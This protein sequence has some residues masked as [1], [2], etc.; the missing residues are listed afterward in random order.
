[1]SN[2]QTNSGGVATQVGIN[3][4][5]RVAAWMCV[6]ILAE[7][8]ASPLWGLSPD[9][10]FEFIRCE[11]EQPVD[12]LLIGTSKG[13]HAFIQVKHRILSVNKNEK[14]AVGS[15]LY[16]FVR[17][18]ICYRNKPNG[19]RSW[20]RSLNPVLDRL[21]LVTN[22]ESSST[23]KFH[24][25]KILNRLQEGLLL[26]ID[27]AAQNNDEKQAL[28][29][30]KYLLNSAWEK[31]TGVHITEDDMLQVLMLMRI[32]VLDVDTGGDDELGAKDRLRSSV[33]DE[34]SQADSVWEHLF[35]ACAM[36]AERSSGADRKILQNYLIN[37]QV[38]LKA[39]RSYQQDIQRLRQYSNSTLKLLK[40]LSIITMGK[41]KAI[42]IDRPSSK[43]LRD[44]SEKNSIVVVGEPGSGKSGALYDLAT[45]LISESRDV[46]FFAVDKIESRSIGSLRQEL[47][48]E[49]QLVDILQNWFGDKPGFLIIDAFDAAR[50]DALGQTLLDVIIA[51]KELQRWNIIVSIRNFDLQHNTRLH[52][53][54]AGSPIDDSFK[55]SLFSNLS[56]IFIPKL[57]INEWK[58]ITKQCPELG[59]LFINTNSKLQE[60][61]LIPFNVKLAAELLSIGVEEK[62]LTPIKTQIGLLDRYWGE[63]VIR[64]DSK[65][66]D[67]EILLRQAVKIMCETRSLVVS[68]ESIATGGGTLNE[69]LS[70]NILGQWQPSLAEAPDRYLLTFAHHI[71]FDYAVARLLLRGTKQNFISRLEEDVDLVIA[72][73]PSVV[74]HFQDKL[75]T[76]N[77]SFWDLTF[78]VIRSAKIPEIGKLI[79]PSTAVEFIEGID[80]FVPLIEA[81]LSES[82]LDTDIPTTAE[83]TLWHL[84]NAIFVEDAIKSNDQRNRLL[85]KP[86]N[87]LI[88][89][90]T[91]TP[92]VNSKIIFC[93]SPVLVML[94]KYKEH[95]SQDNQN[96]LGRAARRLL[97]FALKQKESNLS[98]VA[99]GI[100]AVCR[101][102]DTDST[103]S[104]SVLKQLLE[105]ERVSKYG[106]KELYRLAIEIEGLMLVD[107][108]LVEQVYLRAFTFFDYSEEKTPMGGS[109]IF[110]FTSTRTQDYDSIRYVLV[111]KYNFF[112]KKNPLNATR[113]LI[114][115]IE[116]EFF[117]QNKEEPDVQEKKSFDFSGKI[118]FVESDGSEIKD[119]GISSQYNKVFQILG[120]FEKHIKEI[121]NQEEKSEEL[122]QILDLIVEKNKAAIIWRRLLFLG[123]K[124]PVT[125]GKYLRS[126]AW[127]EPILFGMDTIHPVGEYLKAI[128]SYLTD[129]ERERVE[130]VILSPSIEVEEHSLQR[131]KNRLLGC[132]NSEFLVTDQAKRMVAEQ[133][134]LNAIPPNKPL[135][136]IGK[137]ESRVYTEEDYLLDNDV[138]LDKEPDATIQRLMKPARGF[139]AN[140]PNRDSS[141]TYLNETL[142]KLRILY[143][144]LLKEG[145]RIHSKLRDVAWCH[146]TEACQAVVSHN[147]LECSEEDVLFI[148]NVLLE[149]TS[150]EDPPYDLI[151]HT[152]FDKTP[153]WSPTTRI[154]A[155]S[156][157]VRFIYHNTLIDQPVIEAIKRLAFDPVPAVRFQI[158]SN[159]TLL[160]YSSPQL[161]WE[162]IERI[163]YEEKSMG[164]LQGFLNGTID[165]IARYHGDKTANYINIIFG[166]VSGRNDA[167]EAQKSY[168]GIAVG[169]YLWQKQA[170]CGDIVNKIVE[171]PGKFV[172]EAKTIIYDL[173]HWLNLGSE[174][175]PDQ[176]GVAVRKGSFELIEKF[177]KSVQ[178]NLSNL[179]VK[180]NKIDYEFW[181]DEDKQEFRELANLADSIC[182]QVYFASGAFKSD[183]P[184]DEEDTKLPSSDSELKRFLDDSNNI[185]EILA[186]FEYANLAHNLIKLLEHYIDIDPMR[187]FLLIGQVIKSSKKDFY[188]Y[189]SVGSE[190]IVKIIKRY[191]AEFRQILQE[192]A[193]CRVTLIE[194]LDTFVDAGWRDALKLSYH[195][196]EIFR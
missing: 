37:K 89:R 102:F 152:G 75:L 156:G 160:Y 142:P 94:C 19:N 161:M 166:R 143:D 185:L 180:N 67:R 165:K 55:S 40:D 7:E 108:S 118:A 92:T 62:T 82:S 97:E 17:Q 2:N 4:Q 23:I 36:Y 183:L 140:Y 20:E 187:I 3:Y 60:L 57:G 34:P 132:L 85:S 28:D 164:V 93:I 11:T 74:M 100:E 186:E 66:D 112:L 191:I 46:I 178:T 188:Q 51:V 47:G 196:E 113:V 173:R 73:R 54:F 129:V 79:G 61:L 69:I 175:S 136:D 13:G 41:D 120:V 138:Q 157:I 87:E 162:L 95:F 158:A 171:N 99:N 18:F 50:S 49:Y 137:V 177:L 76:D 39:T 64:S 96:Y 174:E 109:R 125:L 127:A 167:T 86:Y 123:A 139:G 168:A 128:F 114:S 105:I 126:L 193:E 104:S 84:M 135:F 131:L 119:K 181:I 147:K 68:R 80:G 190:L 65:G 24:I 8:E 59:N 144:T 56:H 192:N 43:S 182:L 148:K 30:I 48:L 98:L 130:Q 116:T 141:I 172:N 103:A 107:A 176:K 78:A 15:T 9:V 149:A 58:Q 155:A 154:E 29:V 115:A 184:S 71:L 77:D 35:Q 70:S 179:K 106:Y 146:L 53:L 170:L 44:A 5:N 150:Y 25:P 124:L 194:I 12:D 72:I 63:R 189:E 153:S 21:V 27:S 117:G 22:S 38:R 88:D 31:V 16:Q 32:Q 133:K 195:L 26:D 159:L 122:E 83:K 90:C 1:M 134:K 81:L 6:R 111:S 33:I 163:S 42:K 91:N 14:D 110:N 151:D 45:F 121:S 101:T 145:S 169:L 52:R 10:K